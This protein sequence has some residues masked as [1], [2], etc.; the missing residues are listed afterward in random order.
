MDIVEKR[1][2]V[3]FSKFGQ[4]KDVSAVSSKTGIATKNF[5]LEINMTMENFMAI[6]DILLCRGRNILVIAEG[7]SPYCWSCGAARHLSK[8]YPLQKR[9]TKDNNTS[10]N[11]AQSSSIQG[12]CGGG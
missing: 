12:N 11:S 2:R 7:R 6:S 1:L 5:L 4:T 10:N 9:G 8:A 3:F